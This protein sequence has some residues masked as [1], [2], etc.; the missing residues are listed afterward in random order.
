MA[1]TTLK[2]IVCI[3]VDD[4][5]LQGYQGLVDGGDNIKLATWESVSMMLQLVSPVI[6]HSQPLMPIQES[7]HNCHQ[8]SLSREGITVNE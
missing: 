1:E 4:V 6:R 5:C 7:G 8:L 3:C 2:I